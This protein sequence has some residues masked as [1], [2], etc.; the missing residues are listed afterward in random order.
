MRTSMLLITA[1]RCMF[2]PL[3]IKRSCRYT[4]ATAPQERLISPSWKSIGVFWFA[5]QT[6]GAAGKFSGNEWKSTRWWICR[7]RSDTRA[8]LPE[9][10]P[11]RRS[12]RACAFLLSHPSRVSR[13]AICSI[14]TPA[15][16]NTVLRQPTAWKR[17]GAEG[18][19]GTVA[20]LAVL[21]PLFQLPFCASH[22]T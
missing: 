13:G 20:A 10:M 8:Q 5:S 3:I 21:T 16:I 4:P 1:R 15:V 2:S 14:N 7:S 18:G 22:N 19:S 12:K 17:L 11:A 9:K 6:P